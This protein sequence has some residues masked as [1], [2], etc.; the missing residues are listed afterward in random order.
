MDPRND[1]PRQQRNGDHDIPAELCDN[2]RM[3]AYWT[4]SSPA[5]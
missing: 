4:T 5:Q 1:Q 2:A 3:S